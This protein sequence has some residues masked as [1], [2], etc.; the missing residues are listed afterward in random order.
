M[1]D[2][3]E[4]LMA[5]V[6]EMR[7]AQNSYFRFKGE[8]WLKKSKAKEKALDDV[9]KMLRRKGYNPDR[10]KTNQQSNEIF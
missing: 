9:V 7:E 4:L 1:H 6:E 5:R 10:F 2:D 3:V 8:T